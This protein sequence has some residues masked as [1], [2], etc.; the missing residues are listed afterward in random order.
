[1][2]YPLKVGD[3]VRVTVYGRRAGRQPGEKGTVVRT[4]PLTAAVLPF[5]VVALD[6]DETD[7]EGVLLIE[8]EIEPDVG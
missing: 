1:M 5:F 3:R 8:C 4:P 7:G 6:R 2:R